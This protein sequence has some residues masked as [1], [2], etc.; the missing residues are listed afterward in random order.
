M[1]GATIQDT[2]AR[3]G[4]IANSSIAFIIDQN[5]SANYSVG[6]DTLERTSKNIER[7]ESNL[8]QLVNL[9]DRLQ[10]ENQSLHERQES[11]VAERAGLV[12]KND[13]ARSRVEAMIARLKALEH[14]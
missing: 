6:M 4:L 1:A 2:D 7:L 13:E 9:N 10:L 11:L 3:C 14:S 12:A 8:Q 5:S